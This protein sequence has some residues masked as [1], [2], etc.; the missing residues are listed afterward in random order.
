MTRNPRHPELRRYVRGGRTKVLPEI[1]RCQV[2]STIR[3]RWLSIDGL[4]WVRAR[5]KRGATA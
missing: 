1:G 4:S 5:N 3:P 2:G